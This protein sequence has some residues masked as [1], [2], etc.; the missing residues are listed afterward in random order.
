MS[1]SPE[2]RALY[3]HDDKPYE[4]N[5][6]Y[7]AVARD[8]RERKDTTPAI[9][10]VRDG[11]IYSFAMKNMGVFDEMARRVF[12]QMVRKHPWLVLKSFF[13]DKPRE[14]VRILFELPLAGLLAL[15]WAALLALGAGLLSTV[16]GLSRP[17]RQDLV[18]ALWGMPLVI[19]LSL[20]TTE[21][22]PTVMI[23]D[24]VLCLFIVICVSRYRLCPMRSRMAAS[25]GT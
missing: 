10:E 12:L 16:A 11:V 2:L 23:V 14:Q 13:Y 5:V 25:R 22:L 24:T 3:L 17:Q 21:V 4:D 20:S 9:V 15:F 18:A 8:L 6:V 1:A 7:D 19:V